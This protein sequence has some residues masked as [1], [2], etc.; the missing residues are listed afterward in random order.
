MDYH[1]AVVE[2]ARRCPGAVLTRDA[3]GSF[4]V[5]LINGTVVGAVD[6]CTM[7]SG[8]LRQRHA[9][10][11]GLSQVLADF[12]ARE[13]QLQAEIA[14][15]R[16]TCTKLQGAVSAAKCESAQ[17]SLQLEALRVENIVLETKL[18]KVSDAE[19]ERIQEAGKQ[20]QRILSQLIVEAS[21]DKA[22]AVRQQ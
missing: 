14:S 17:L 20:L 12:A 4:I 7:A 1:E 8:G 3:S 22:W 5:R 2:I 16:A 19:W 6:G 15:L 9:H 13:A 10:L 11:E 21:A 18:E